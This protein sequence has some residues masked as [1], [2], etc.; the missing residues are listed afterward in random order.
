MLILSITYGNG[1][2]MEIAFAG[3]DGDG[4]RVQWGRLGTDLNFT[5]TDGDGDICSSPCRALL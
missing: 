2:G 1:E 5:G 4:H 3:T